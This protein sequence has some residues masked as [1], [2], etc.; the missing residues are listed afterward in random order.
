VSPPPLLLAIALLAAPTPGGAEPLRY[1][2]TL[3]L[4]LP[5]FEACVP[6]NV[7]P[8]GWPVPYTASG[9]GVATV[10]RTGSGQLQS[11]A[12]AGGTFS[13]G[14]T[15]HIGD[16]PAD[17]P[18]YSIAAISV[19]NGA[20][21]FGPSGGTMP[22]AGALRICLFSACAT[23]TAAFSVPL[24]VVGVGGSATATSQG[25]SVTV[26]GAPWTAGAVT[27]D[28]LGR[29]PMQFSG[30]AHGPASV[31]SSV[32]LASG[33]LQ[34]VT[35]VY[36]STSVAAFPVFDLGVAR[37]TLHFVPEPG[38]LL[39]VAGGLGVLALRGGRPRRARGT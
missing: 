36:V 39:L 37:L 20:A 6:G 19:G 4:E 7:P 25:V 15:F 18:L 9:S 11:L 33:T 26:L 29:G 22:L 27:V 1:T 10:V 14:G 23:P 24:S 12:L 8:C 38:S 5:G 13:I 16:D 3:E 35:P 34:L 2:G 21:S 17:F 30:F 28:V 31:P 32:A